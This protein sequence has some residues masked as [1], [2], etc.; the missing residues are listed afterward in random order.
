MRESGFSHEDALAGIYSFGGN[1]YVHLEELKP[2]LAATI[3][4]FDM[5]GKQVHNQQMITAYATVDFSH[6]PSGS[7]IVQMEVENAITRK[8][9]FVW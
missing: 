8:Q 5:L 2:G 7:Y 1:I 3:M 9:V 4:V 6:Q